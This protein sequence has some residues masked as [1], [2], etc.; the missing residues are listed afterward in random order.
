MCTSS[1]KEYADRLFTLDIVKVPNGQVIQDYDFKPL[2]DKAK[3]FGSLEPEETTTI[4]T[5]FGL[6]TILSLAPKI[7]E[8]VEAGKIK[9]FFLLEVVILSIQKWIIIENL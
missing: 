7:K 6:S 3:E 2:I 1:K 4:N 8:L 9:R 5:G